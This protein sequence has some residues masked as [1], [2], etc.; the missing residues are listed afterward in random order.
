[1][2]R[3]NIYNLMLVAAMAIAFA[4]CGVEDNSGA[5]FSESVNVSPEPLLSPAESTIVHYEYKYNLGEFL[6]EDYLDLAELYGQVGRIRDQRDLLEQGYRLFEDEEILEALQTI[7]VNLAEEKEIITQEAQIMLNNLELEEYRDEAINMIVN[8]QWFDTMMPKLM[9]GRRNYYLERNGQVALVIQAGYS[10]EGAPFSNVWYTGEEGKVLLITQE[11]N[12]LQMLETSLNE[13]CYEGEFEAWSLDGNTGDMIWEEGTFEN[14]ACAGAYTIGV[15][16]GK[17]GS[18]LFSLWSNKEGMSYTEYEGSLEADGKTFVLG[19]LTYTFGEEALKWEVYPEFVTYAVT[20]QENVSVSDGSLEQLTQA[21][22]EV[23]QAS[24]APQIRIFDG[25]IQYHDG[26]KWVS[27]GEIEDLSKEDPFYSY[28]AAR[29]SLMEATWNGNAGSEEGNG[30]FMDKL[31]VL[32]L[33]ELEEQAAEEAIEE[34]EPTPVPTATPKP[35]AKPS[36]PA[37]PAMPS[38]P[39]PTPSPTPAPTPTPEAEPDWSP[40]IENDTDSDVEPE[41]EDRPGAEETPESEETPEPDTGSGEDTDIEWSD[42]IL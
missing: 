21:T 16:E 3:K 26:E 6:Q 33:R 31:G 20:E 9:E 14:G 27:L 7:T 30:R 36:K 1:M 40:D 42:D 17:G 10:E 32:S 5:M 19:E 4:G 38:N 25:M 35:A 29:D 24:N 28:T 2:K 39:A 13:G 41:P 22:E 11:G 12:T 18:D 8:R 15:S 34:P 23:Q 37:S